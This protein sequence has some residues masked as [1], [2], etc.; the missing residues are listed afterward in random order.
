MNNFF[1]KEPKQILDFVIISL[2]ALLPISLISRS[3]IINILTFLIGLF[4]L[5]KVLTEKKFFFLNNKIFYALCLFWLTL[6]VNLAFSTDFGASFLRS[7]GFFKFV[8]LVFAIKYYLTLENFKYENFIFKAWFLAFAIV[9]IDLIFEYIFGFNTLGYKSYMPGRLSG[10]LDQELKIGHFYYGFFLI[11]TS[12]IYKNYNRGLLFFISIGAF[13]TI[14]FIIG[15]RSAF[16]KGFL[17]FFFFLLLFD[18]YNFYRKAIFI[19]LI[20]ALITTLI[21]TN[22]NYKLRFW[23]QLFNPMPNQNNLIKNLSKTSY[24]SHYDTAIKIFTKYPYFGS[25]LKTFRYESSKKKYT[26]K[27]RSQN[28]NRMRWATHPHNIHLEFLSETGIFGYLSF[29][30]FFIYVLSLS[31]KNFLK[32]RNNYQLASMLYIFFTLIPIL[33]SGSFFT[34]YAATI[35]WI[36]FAIMI[37]YNFQK[38]N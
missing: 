7:F 6:L 1:R 38:K 22:Q 29:I 3:L 10:F 27:D 15:E 18:K 4:F 30:I 11:G 19:S 23:T 13:V 26:D 33:P 25:G 21:F 8:L 14:L 2:I 37:S 9:S 17:M 5:I 16:I 28:F 35:F 12:F 24:A 20:S 36:N 32:F 34:T 31:V